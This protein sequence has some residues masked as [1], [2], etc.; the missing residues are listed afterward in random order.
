MGAEIY[1][2]VWRD[3]DERDDR[4]KIAASIAVSAQMAS[5]LSRDLIAGAIGESG[6]AAGSRATAGAGGAGDEVRECD[7]SGGDRGAVGDS[8]GAGAG[9]R[10]SRERAA[11]GRRSTAISCPEQPAAIFAAGKQAHVPLLAGRKCKEQG[12][13]ASWGA[14]EATRES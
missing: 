11:S 3:P 6:S 13:A 5:P 4:G 2:G 7:G 1:R 8:G 12:W 9:Q 14:R 10:V